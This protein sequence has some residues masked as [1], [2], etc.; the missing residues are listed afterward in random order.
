M[1]IPDGF[2]SPPV[3]GALDLIS[4]PV[5]GAIARKSRIDVEE[6]RIPLLGVM[7]AFVFAAQMINFPVG[8]G[9]SGHL[10]GGALLAC[11]LGPVAAAMV[12]TA[13]VGIQALV[14]QDGGIV[15]LGAN[16]LNMAV[17]GVFAGYLPYH[18]F[19]ARWRRPAIFIGAFLSVLVSAL[20]ALC[21]LLVSGVP[22]PQGILIGSFALF[23]VSAAIEGVI[24]VAAIEAIDRLQPNWIGRATGLRSPAFVSIA[25]AAILLVSLGVTIA[26][27][28]PDGIAKLAEQT[29]IS[30]HAK[31]FI[32]TPLSAYEL[33]GISLPWAAKAVAG[34]TGLFLIFTLCV[35]G[36]RAFQRR[37]RPDIAGEGA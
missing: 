37:V 26:S 12:M 3:W 34:L 21:E 6:T 20:M 29:G 25:I 35:A 28:A 11:T 33:S 30:G 16:V 7:G 18:F 27:T 19:G 5:V 31:T 22:M 15:A 32:A 2:L 1:H 17:A 10:V 23:T 4:L 8:L 24:T 14:F 13:I 9:T 36:A